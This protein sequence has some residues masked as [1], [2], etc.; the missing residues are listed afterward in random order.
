DICGNTFVAGRTKRFWKGWSDM[1]A[2]A[3]FEN[4][5]DLIVELRGQV[6]NFHRFN[7][8]KHSGAIYCS[9]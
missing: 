2:I 5:K 4:L 9:R 1:S 3:K 6:E 8:L 7:K